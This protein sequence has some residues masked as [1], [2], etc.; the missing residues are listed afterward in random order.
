MILEEFSAVLDKA[1]QQRADTIGVG[2]RKHPVVA[3]LVGAVFVV[4]IPV[5]LMQ[6]QW[7]PSAPIA[8]SEH[9]LYAQGPTRTIDADAGR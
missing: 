4:V 3:V 8:A 1:R 5:M 9:P 6:V 7:A 2:I